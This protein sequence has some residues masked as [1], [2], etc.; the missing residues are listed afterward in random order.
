M[1]T[2]LFFGVLLLSLLLIAG[3]AAVTAVEEDT[4]PHCE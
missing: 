1:K 3:T 2:I 4:E